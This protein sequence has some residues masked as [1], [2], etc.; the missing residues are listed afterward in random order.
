MV[1]EPVVFTPEMDIAAIL[2]GKDAVLVPKDF[3]K[4]CTLQV[5]RQ[6]H[7]FR[8]KLIRCSYELDEVS[9]LYL[10]EKTRRLLEAKNI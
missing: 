5:A 2:K 9:L 7:N 10:Q 6:L 1:P 4:Y 3:E 8:G